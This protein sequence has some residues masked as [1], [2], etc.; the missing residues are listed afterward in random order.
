[1]R[2][3]HTIAAIVGLGLSAG[4]ATTALADTTASSSTTPF[5]SLDAQIG[6]LLGE[7]RSALE[8]LPQ[9]HLGNLARPRGGAAPLPQYTRAWLERTPTASGGPE[10]QCLSEALYFEAR[11]ETPEGQAA[12]AEV[13]LNRKASS[14]YPNSVCGVV[15]QGTGRIHGCQFSYTCDGKP[16]NIDN[17]GAYN[18]VGKVARAVMDGAPRLIPTDVTHYH[19]NAVS[20]SWASQYERTGQIGVHVFYRQYYPGRTASN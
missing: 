11:G 6:S 20:P 17:R 5:A 7:E 12:V 4:A 8:A 19:T 3:T 2:L 1:V 16:E 14:R 9:G 13:I 10:W 18:N 15:N